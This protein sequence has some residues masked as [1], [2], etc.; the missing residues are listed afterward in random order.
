MIDKEGLILN[1][2]ELLAKYQ[3]LSSSY[4]KSAAEPKAEEYVITLFKLLGWDSLSEEVIP[5][6]KI[7][8]ASTY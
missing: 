6:Q 1:I 7:K 3:G 5:Q 8:R 4:K 2:K